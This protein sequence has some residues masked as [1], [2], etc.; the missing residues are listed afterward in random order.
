MKQSLN[1]NLSS[2]SF[3]DSEDVAFLKQHGVPLTVT[4]RKDY[5][6][7]YIDKDDVL[8]EVSLSD[9]QKIS[10]SFNVEVTPSGIIISN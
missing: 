3:P 10:N 1:V 8:S 6:E 5:D 2:L 7:Y 4:Q 9:L